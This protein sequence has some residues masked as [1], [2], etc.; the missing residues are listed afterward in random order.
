VKAL[1]RETKSKGIRSIQMRLESSLR[2]AACSTD[3]DAQN[4]SGKVAGASALVV[5]TVSE[6]DKLPEQLMSRVANSSFRQM[7]IGVCF[8]PDPQHGY[9]NFWVV[10]AF[11]S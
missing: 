11:Y 8:R 10:A 5:F 9:A 3:G 4:S 2:D 7:A 1:N 6:P